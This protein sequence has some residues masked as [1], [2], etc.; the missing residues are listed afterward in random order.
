MGYDRAA[1]AI[2]AVGTTGALVGA[3]VAAF[4]FATGRAGWALAGSVLLI[5]G[6]LLRIE[7][8]LRSR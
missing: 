6:L 8:A 4:G 2:L 5:S 1:N 7:A 3:V